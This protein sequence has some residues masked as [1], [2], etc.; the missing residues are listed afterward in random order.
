MPW[1]QDLAIDVEREYSANEKGRDGADLVV[2]SGK[3]SFSL[4][5]FTEKKNRITIMHL[6]I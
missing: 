5:F 4:Q 3:I 6:M 1:L 2:W